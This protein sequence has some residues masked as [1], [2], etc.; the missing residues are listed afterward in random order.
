MVYLSALSDSDSVKKSLLVE[1]D[2][3][4]GNIF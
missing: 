2:V 1:F 4:E 3:S